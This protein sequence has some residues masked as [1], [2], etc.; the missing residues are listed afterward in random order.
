VQRKGIIA[1]IMKAYERQ[2]L[3]ASTI[4]VT[5][6]SVTSTKKTRTT[7]DMSTMWQVCG[8]RCGAVFWIMELCDVISGYQE[9]EEYILLPSSEQK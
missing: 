1:S 4:S 8:F 7:K 6:S 2:L 3:F 5:L 9:L